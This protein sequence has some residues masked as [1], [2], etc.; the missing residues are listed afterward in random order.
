MEEVRA[1]RRAQLEGVLGLA[2]WRRRRVQEEGGRGGGGDE[3]PGAY[4]AAAADARSGG[5]AAAGGVRCKCEEHQ[6]EWCLPAR[7]AA[8]VPGAACGS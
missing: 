2:G 7:E 1:E 6:R 3:G 5:A 4:H 8:R